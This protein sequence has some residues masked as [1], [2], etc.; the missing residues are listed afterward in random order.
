MKSLHVSC[1]LTS[2]IFHLDKDELASDLPL[3]ADCKLIIE[4]LKK[5]TRIYNKYRVVSY[6]N[7]KCMHLYC[8]STCS[9]QMVVS[10]KNT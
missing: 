9:V 1:T 4:P 5:K 8:T 2:I 6:I 3:I 7:K 10:H